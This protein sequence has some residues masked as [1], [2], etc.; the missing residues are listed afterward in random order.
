MVGPG[1]SDQAVYRI[2]KDPK[3]KHRPGKVIHGKLEKMG[4]SQKITSEA[5]AAA[6]ES[7]EEYK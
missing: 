2:R 6:V 3:V 5:A 4:K 7:E 1:G